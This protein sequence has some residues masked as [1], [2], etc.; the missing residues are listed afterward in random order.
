MDATTTRP[1]TS[2]LNARIFAHYERRGHDFV[3]PL[4][5]LRTG[6]G[7]RLTAQGHHLA[8]SGTRVVFEAEQ[9]ERAVRGEERHLR[10][11]RPPPPACLARR[12][13]AADD[14]VAELDR[15]VGSGH[16]ARRGD[17]ATDLGAELLAEREDVRRAVLPAVTPVQTTH[18][19][20]VHERERDDRARRQTVRARRTAHRATRQ[21]D[22][23]G[24][25]AADDDPH[26]PLAATASGR[27]RRAAED[28]RCDL[29][30]TG[31]ARGT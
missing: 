18:L 22:I 9:M 31:C 8:V 24:W 12:L 16:E 6:G 14:D 29:P 7:D 30:G 27:K 19:F 5:A 25:R 21:R 3:A 11:E 2:A 17:R 28:A 1:A 10:G 15:A 20:V 4:T 26:L 23:A 13:R